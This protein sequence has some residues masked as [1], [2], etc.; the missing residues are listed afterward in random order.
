MTPP[1]AGCNTGALISRSFLIHTL[2]RKEPEIATP[3]LHPAPV[4]QDNWMPAL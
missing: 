2:M 3:F 4:L 1:G